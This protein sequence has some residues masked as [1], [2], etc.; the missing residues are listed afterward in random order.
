MRADEHRD[1]EEADDELTEATEQ[2]QSFLRPR[3]GAALAQHER[4]ELLRRRARTG[5]L[6]GC[7]CGCVAA[8][9]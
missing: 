1:V 9:T 4:E 7:S 2:S 5:R 8:W 3:T 6:L